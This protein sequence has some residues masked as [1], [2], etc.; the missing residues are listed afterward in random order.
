MPFAATWK[1]LEIIILSE[2]REDMIPLLC[3][4]L[5]KNTNEFI[6]QTDSHAENKLVTKREGG[7]GVN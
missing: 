5:K 1:N 6:Y 4:I 3:G 2:I 7:G